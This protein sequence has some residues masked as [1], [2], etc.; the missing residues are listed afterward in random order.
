MGYTSFDFTEYLDLY[1]SVS[2]L[3]EDKTRGKYG[4]VW[5]L[6]KIVGDIF[7][8]NEKK[9]VSKREIKKMIPEI[10]L[11]QDIKYIK[12]QFNQIIQ[13]KEKDWLRKD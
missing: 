6:G 12:H 2:K 4:S 5:W 8:F 13:E 9:Q 11:D 7:D 3:I 10:D 1:K